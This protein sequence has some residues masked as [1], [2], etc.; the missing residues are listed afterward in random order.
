MAAFVLKK[1]YFEF[2]GEVKQQIS[3]KAIGT[4]FA[5]PYAY[6]LMGEVEI[7]FLGTKT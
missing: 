5:P 3:E 2:I 4:N 7:R 1:S 6:I